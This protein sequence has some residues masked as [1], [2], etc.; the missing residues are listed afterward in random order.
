MERQVK[1]YGKIFNY[2]FSYKEFVEIYAK[3]NEWYG[4]KAFLISN[5]IMFIPL[6]V[7]LPMLSKWMRHI[8]IYFSLAIVCSISIEVIQLKYQLGYC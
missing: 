3:W 1:L 5:I 7:F 6:G 8:M 2:I 4:E